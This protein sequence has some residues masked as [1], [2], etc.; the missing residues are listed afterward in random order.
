MPTPRYDP[1]VHLTPYVTLFSR[2]VRRTRRLNTLEMPGQ[3]NLTDVTPGFESAERCVGFL[4][5]FTQANNPYI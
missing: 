5:S 1:T 4:A 3:A 2:F